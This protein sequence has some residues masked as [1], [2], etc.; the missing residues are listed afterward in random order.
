MDQPVEIREVNTIEEY[1]ACVRLQKEVF[2]LPDLEISPRRHLI[3]SAQAG[4]WTLGAFI[5]GK[6]IGFVHHLAAVRGS[7]VFGYS[8]MMAVAAEYQNFGIGAKLKWAQRARALSEGREFIKWTFE[9]VR[10]RNAHFNLNRL[11]VV[12]RSYAVNFYGTD[13]ATNRAE[14]SAGP[15]GMDSDRLF[16][17]WELRS[18]RVQAL[19]DGRDVSAGAPDGVIEIPNDFGALLKSDPAEAKAEAL[20]IR[21]EF[22]RA[23][24]A[25]LVCRAFER[26]DQ[27]PKYLLYRDR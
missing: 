20:R 23:F 3:V 25:G 21:E 2:G 18:P 26:D 27:P 4:G 14:R 5:D 13:Y 12:V 24:S 17:S 8:H 10:A 22:L 7:E 15:L 19:A 11:G 1:D 16:A 6:L 9:P